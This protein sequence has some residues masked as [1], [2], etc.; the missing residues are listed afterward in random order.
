MGLQFILHIRV[1]LHF[2][3]QRNFIV[4]C[5]FFFT[6]KALFINLEVKSTEQF[7]ETITPRDVKLI[8]KS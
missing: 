8:L 7:S 1:E 4:F 5:P 6:L 2:K 3:S